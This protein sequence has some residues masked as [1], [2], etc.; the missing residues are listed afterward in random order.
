MVF[1]TDPA[2]SGC[3]INVRVCD[4][5]RMNFG[6]KGVSMRKTAGA[7]IGGLVFIPAVLFARDI[8][9]WWMDRGVINTNSTMA[10]NDFALA[11]QGQL[12]WM[13]LQCAKEFE[14]RL[15]NGAGPVIW[16]TV[17][18][19]TDA[20]NSAALNIGQLKTVSK[21]FY[22]RLYPAH[23][24]VCPPELPG[25]YPWSF[26]NGLC[27]DHAAVNIGQLKQIFNFDFS[28]AGLSP[29]DTMSVSGHIDYSGTQEGLVIVLVSLVNENGWG[30]AYSVQLTQPGDY[31]ISGLPKGRTGWVRAFIDTDGN[32]IGNGTEP[33]GVYVSNP[34]LLDSLPPG[35][36][37]DNINITLADAGCDGDSLPD[38]WELRRFGS[39]AQND[40]TD[41]DG[42]GLTD[43]EE[44]LAG[45]DPT[46][47]DTDGDG[48]ADGWEVLHGF[49][50][51]S[52]ADGL[53]DADGDGLSNLEE[54]ERQTDPHV[55]GPNGLLV[56]IPGSGTRR[57]NEPRLELGDL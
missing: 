29:V 26:P 49:N 42:D 24:N 15:L 5:S 10:R 46:K 30:M 55:S 56:I 50:P 52:A 33:W 2:A 12:K 7:F 8:P 21:P 53:A 40:M 18:K 34:L 41:Y 3:L 45:T 1:L 38:W 20:N 4:K 31:T 36:T 25:K 54:F 43:Y 44:Y 6:K 22:D 32:G 28:R 14:C 27:S 37:I 19:F 23:T 47:M 16:E 11:N 39:L 17:S 9:R 13:A 57:V 51:L 48:M 35:N